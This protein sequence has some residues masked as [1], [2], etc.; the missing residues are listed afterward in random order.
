M[1]QVKPSNWKN[2]VIGKKGFPAS[3][4][5][6]NI[7]MCYLKKFNGNLGDKCGI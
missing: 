1:I 5:V 7:K 3:Q 4:P 2:P 6:S